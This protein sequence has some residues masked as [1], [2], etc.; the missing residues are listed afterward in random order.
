M[1]RIMDGRNA[2]RTNSCTFE[3]W[4]HKQREFR[5]VPSPMNLDRIFGEVS[6]YST[7]PK[8]HARKV[9]SRVGHLRHD[10]LRLSILTSSSEAL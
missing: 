7:C 9:A 10:N 5:R 3:A 4:F 2:G 6:D 1:H 8:V